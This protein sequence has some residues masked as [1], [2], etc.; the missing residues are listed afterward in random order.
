MIQLHSITKTF[1]KKNGPLV[2]A[3]QDIELEVN[4]GE[5]I[6]IT[7]PS[8]SGKSTLLFTI[9]AMQRPTKGQVIMKGTDIYSLSSSKRA[10]LR[11]KQIGFVFQ[12][13]NLIPYLNC[14]ENVILPA[15]LAGE[16]RTASLKKA[17]DFL[18]RLGLEKRFNHRP[19]ELSVGE[20]QRVAIC[21]SLI[22][23]PEVILADEPTGNMD[24]A[25]REEVMDVLHN[26]NADG[27]TIIMI[28][29]DPKLAK[30]GTRR[31]SLNDGLI[32][33]DTGK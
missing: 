12:T 14:I 33:K 6:M 26:L 30:E 20:R 18:K 21:R 31:V 25:M 4:Q 10:L 9:G 16:V 1:S 8:G 3:L 32:Q 27:Q 11:R 28:T 13:F 17:K 22:N 5:F 15:V 23:S 7:G 29:H 24:V 2:T 19:S